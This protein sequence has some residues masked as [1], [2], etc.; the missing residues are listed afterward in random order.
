MRRLTITGLCGTLAVGLLGPGW[1]VHGEETGEAE[2]LV[3]RVREAIARIESVEGTYR[4]YF[5]PK[6][7]GRDS[8]AP[9]GLMPGHVEGPDG[10]ILYSEFDWA[11]QA[12]PYREAIDGRRGFEVGGW[13]VFQHLEIVYDGAILRYFERETHSG[14][15]GPPG[16][17]WMYFAT[18][19][20][21]LTLMGHG[22]GYRPG[23]DLAAIL[24]GA[25]LVP[26][27]AGEPQLKGLRSRFDNGGDTYEITA[28][29]DTAH[30][31]LP[32]RIEV[33]NLS[34]RQP[35]RTR[36]IVNDDI[37]EVRPGLWMVLRGEE[38]KYYSELVPPPGMTKDDLL[39]L[40]RAE[41]LALFPRLGLVALPLGLGTQ[42]Y[43]LDESTL[44]VNEPIPAERFAM[45][46]PEGTSVNDTTHDPPLQYEVKANG[47]PEE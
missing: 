7:P 31:F 28:W 4:T 26:S 39:A 11:W 46:F 20:N 23:R 16:D 47:T 33:V 36:L 9:D 18:I 41:Q 30:G 12:E 8:I 38:T 15:V 19:R 29:I 6:T 14:R 42:T 2:Q 35:A 27:P 5:S 37:R 32:R 22:A 40:P 10:L 43:I 45:E 25:E 24:D 3:E 17:A 44:R 1:A 13:F 21:P 34:Q